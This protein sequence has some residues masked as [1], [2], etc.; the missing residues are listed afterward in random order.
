M[1]SEHRLQPLLRN[2]VDT[3]VVTLA[4]STD[5]RGHGEREGQYA[6]DL[7]V[8]GPLVQSLLDA[9]LGVLS[10]EAGAIDLDRA[11]VAVVDPVDGSTNA[12]R[13]IPW[14]NTSICIVDD[15]GPLLSIIENHVTRE[16]FEAVRGGGATR[17]GFPIAAPAPSRMQDAI[18]AVNGVPPIDAPWAQFRA[19]GASA[20]D[21]SY[22]AIGAIDAYVDFADEGHGVWDYLGALL[23]C[24]ELGVHLVDAFDREL[25]HLDHAERR[26]PIAAHDAETLRLLTEIRRRS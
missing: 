18:V 16:R 15:E 8:D 26:T 20:L 14:Y 9:G 11:L 6:L 10:E 2:V 22:V 12:S 5:R 21:L 25:V 23:I 13:S 24:R 4:A 7:L 1:A 17:N 3:A 19:L